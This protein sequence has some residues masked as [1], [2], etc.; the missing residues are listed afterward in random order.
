MYYLVYKEI[1]LAGIAVELEEPVYFDKYNKIL[2]YQT[3]EAYGCPSRLRITDPSYMLVDDETGSSTNMKKDK[4][5]NEK[6]I[7]EHGFSGSKEA[8]SSDLRYTTMGFTSGDGKPIMCCI[9]FSSESQRGIPK[10]WITGI[11][12]TKI[13]ID[14]V[15][16][17]NDIDLISSIKDVGSIAGGGPRCRFRDVDVPCMVQYSSHGGITGKLLTNCLRKMDE[18]KLFPRVDNKL[19][20]LLVDG[21]DSRYDKE[22][23]EYIHGE[24]HMWCCCIGLP[25]GT[26]L[27]HVGDSPAQNGNF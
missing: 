9:I 2:D 6:V 22:F 20:F 8:I 11:D 18:L 17:D 16:P 27:W 25:Y 26:H 19:P 13:S 24:D 14:F 15:I 5:Y 21:H 10:N 12:I 7:A 23:L 1:L 3:D 4:T